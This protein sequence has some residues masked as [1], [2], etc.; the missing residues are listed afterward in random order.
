VT[1]SNETGSGGER[2]A[3]P[4]TPTHGAPGAP[5][6]PE[7]R[8]AAPPPSPPFTP[9]RPVPPEPARP[10][11]G[12]SRPP[13]GDREARRP[14]DGS[15]F[16][17]FLHGEKPPPASDSDAPAPS[18]GAT[19]AGEPS[20]DLPAGAPALPTPWTPPASR[21]EE[22]RRI[23]AEV[24][25]R[26]HKAQRQQAAQTRAQQIE[27]LKQQGEQAHASD[28][29]QASEAFMQARAL[30]QQEQHA[31][32]LVEFLDRTYVDPWVEDA[33]PGQ[34]LEAKR[35]WV[36]AHGGEDADPLQGR[37]AVLR[38]ARD[39]F[40]ARIRQDE[41]AKLR[42]SPAF[43]K[44]V[45]ADWRSNPSDDGLQ[46]PELVTGTNGTRPALGMNDWLRRAGG[47]R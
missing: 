11:T 37:Q 38:A 21:D 39:A 36:A 41:A 25:R 17:R 42:K 2:P 5:A 24:D 13:D 9:A 35:A 4:A 12:A 46:E 30:E 45:L 29:Y 6:A 40:E 22:E 3:P 10:P 14:S 15:W 28:A 1:V 18:T 34:T 19:E 8:P 23:Q 47:V 32:G 33:L 44:Q 16:R 26:A 43:R 7:S 20:P 31:R 27:A